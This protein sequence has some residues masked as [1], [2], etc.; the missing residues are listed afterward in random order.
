MVTDRDLVIQILAEEGPASG[1][2]VGDIMSSDL[3]Y[4]GRSH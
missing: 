2:T 1:I 4:G 3:R